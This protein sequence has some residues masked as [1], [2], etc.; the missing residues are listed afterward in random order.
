MAVFRC[1]MCGA[2]LNV[3]DGQKIATCE[4]CG[5]TQTIPLSDNERKTA[6]YNRAIS[7]R[8]ENKFDEALYAY[9]SIVN[10]FNSDSEAHWGVCLCKYGIEYVDDPRTGDKIPTCHRTLF[11]SILNDSDYLEA[12]KNADEVTK[13]IYTS[14]ARQIDKIQK[15]IISISQTK[16]SY[17]V[18]ISYKESDEN[19]NRTKES[20]IGE[21]IYEKLTSKGL[22]VFFSRISL[23]KK[24]GHEYEPIIFTAL[25]TAKVMV[26]IGS[27]TEYFNAPWVKNEWSRFLSFMEKEK[28]KYL[29]PCF[30][31]MSPYD[32]PEEFLVFQAQDMSKIGAVQDLVRGVIK[33]V[34]KKI[35]EKPVQVNALIPNLDIY[36][37]RIDAALKKDSFER[38]DWIADEVL[39]LDPNNA[40]AFYYKFLINNKFKSFDDLYKKKNYDLSKDENFNSAL[41]FATGQYKEELEKLYNAY[42]N[43]NSKELYAKALDF[44]DKKNYIN[45]AN[46]FKSIPNYLDSATKLK[47]CENHYNEDYY[48]KGLTYLQ[49]NDF[50]N[51]LNYFKQ[52]RGY[53]DS[54]EKIKIAEEGDLSSRYE[55]AV[56][57]FNKGLFD[58]ATNIFN[59]LGDYKDSKDYIANITRQRNYV[60]ARNSAFSAA[61]SL[62]LTKYNQAI[63]LLKKDIDYKDSKKD[64]ETAKKIY[65]ESLK[66]R[67]K[68]KRKKIAIATIITTI[69]SLCISFL[70][71]FI[72]VINPI[73]KY[74]EA[75]N[76]LANES[77]DEAREVYSE[78]GD[79]KDSAY[80]VE[81]IDEFNSLRNSA[82]NYNKKFNNLR[83]LGVTS[84]VRF[85]EPS[86][87]GFY[88]FKTLIVNETNAYKEPDYVKEGYRIADFEL[89]YSKLYEN[90][91]EL[92]VTAYMRGIAKPIVYQA[93]LYEDG[94]D[95]LSPDSVFDFTI[96]TDSTYYRYAYKPG[97]DHVGWV[98]EYGNFNENIEIEKNTIGDRKFYA[99]FEPIVYDIIYH[100]NGGTLS[101]DY[102]K[103]YTIEQMVD[104]PIPKK[105]GYEFEG[106][107]SDYYLTDPVYVIAKGNYGTIDLYAKYSYADYLITF[108]P[109]GGY[110]DPETNNIS[111]TY[112]YNGFSSDETM[113]IYNGDTIPYKRPYISSNYVF[114][115][116]YQDSSFE[117]KFDFN[118]LIAED[119][120]LYLKCVEKDYKYLDDYSR[121]IN[122]TLVSGSTNIIYEE[123]F[124]APYDCTLDIY[125]SFLSESAGRSVRLYVDNLTTGDTNVY[126]LS[127]SSSTYLQEIDFKAGDNVEISVVGL[128]KNINTYNNRIVYDIS[129]T[130][131]YTSNAKVRTMGS[132]HPYSQYVTYK[133]SLI[134]PNCNKDNFRFIGWEFSGDIYKDRISSWNYTYGGILKAV[135]EPIS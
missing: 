77:Y 92:K 42:N 80:R 4:Y 1:K 64:I 96:E 101:G 79:Y 53:K 123:R 114:C 109:N 59:E 48:Q 73:L 37:R 38:A 57:F 71:V 50:Y 40:K 45:A 6:L 72:Y 128:D 31:D 121:Q 97:Y 60:N 126:D 131:S 54:D 10:E 102:P 36:F 9:Q 124:T 16:E 13:E 81:V 129:S 132:T 113:T 11:E 17:D 21:E 7:L 116:W 61:R 134:L 94:T 15:R 52:I 130:P 84:T 75:Y 63:E 18:F 25:R 98:D 90:N 87:G 110:F 125:F 133:G 108:D 93:Y 51:A 34:G 122:S 35:E 22:K 47:E 14:E 67:K 41:E 86:I 91:G 127:Y 2:D 107:Y 89:T 68:A 33:L 20:L 30:I 74:D 88:S 99:V 32:M 26:V 119:L 3:K 39:S 27:K 23:E 5:S 66:R 112:H 120:D 55:N 56:Q 29:I 76:L 70:F 65:D 135:F 82:F 83:N 44:L 12:I 58:E 43:R 49:S 28:E 111:V 103:T 104:L 118:G 78:L 105:S 115:G 85:E 100:T 106:W 46:I 19:N 62:N 8:L 24:L 69:V 117:K 95:D